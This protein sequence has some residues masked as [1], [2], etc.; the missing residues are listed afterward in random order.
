MAL[1]GANLLTFLN[2]FPGPAVAIKMLRCRN[3]AFRPLEA[4]RRRE[5]YIC[6]AG[7]LP[8]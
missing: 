2:T 5:G 3:H 7:G 6:P 1:A 4:R 8:V